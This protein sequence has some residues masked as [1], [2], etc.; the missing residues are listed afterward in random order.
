MSTSS[1]EVLSDEASFCDIVASNNSNTKTNNSI[2]NNN[3]N[4]NNTA[5]SSK[6]KKPDIS[7]YFSSFNE[8]IHTDETRPNS[9]TTSVTMG[10]NSS[11]VPK[12][13]PTSLK[14]HRNNEE[15]SNLL[16]KPFINAMDS[17]FAKARV[18]S[19][20][21]TGPPTLPLEEHPL[22]GVK[23]NTVSASTTSRSDKP[24]TTSVTSSALPSRSSTSNNAKKDNK[25]NCNQRS[26]IDRLLSNQRNNNNL[27]Q[28]RHDEDRALASSSSSSSS[29]IDDLM[30]CERCGKRLLVWDLPDHMDFHFAKD[31]QD[32]LKEN[33]FT[34]CGNSSSSSSSTSN[35][36]RKDSSLSCTKKRL[37]AESPLKKPSKKIKNSDEINDSSNQRLLKYFS[38]IIK[39]HNEP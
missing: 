12:Q 20:T 10:N 17:F 8:N 11:L 30:S 2:N 15:K 37:Q 29:S 19:S 28:R 5:I 6:P 16:K 13:T 22:L 39:K 21:V 34:M 38:P 18:A 31:L 27:F 35:N 33:F 25:T 3:N 36:I 14:N 9:A 7:K 26:T 1:S 32:S 24:P 4:I 23:T